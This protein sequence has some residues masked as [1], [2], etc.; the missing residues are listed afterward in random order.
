MS[1]RNLATALRFEL[2]LEV[3]ETSVLPLNYA[4]VNLEG[5]VGIEPNEWEI[6]SLLPYHLATAP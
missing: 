4:E 6:Q 2:R 3:L 5:R 1:R